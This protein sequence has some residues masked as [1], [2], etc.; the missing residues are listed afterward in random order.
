M[1][2]GRL[3]FGK[4]VHVRG[5]RIHHGLVGALLVAAGVVYMADDWHDRWWLPV[6]ELLD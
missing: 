3:G 1:A 2:K 4:Q 6:K 5:R